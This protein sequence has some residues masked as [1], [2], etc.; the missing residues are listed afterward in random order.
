[1]LERRK[2]H[3]SGKLV[4]K[5]FLF[6]FTPLSHIETCFTFVTKKINTYAQYGLN[7]SNVMEYFTKSPFYD[8][9]SIHGQLRM[10]ARFNYYTTYNNAS[11]RWIYTSFFKAYRFTIK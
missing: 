1:M 9:T 6:T 11:R 10:Q 3:S 5:T 8:P 2:F 4:E 7:L